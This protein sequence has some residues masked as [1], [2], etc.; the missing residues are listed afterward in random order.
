MATVR[1][2]SPMRRF[3]NGERVVTVA[4]GT[5]GDAI[6]DLTGRFPGLAERLLDGDG[7]LYDFVNVFVNDQDARLLQGLSTPVDEGSEISIIPAM[8]GGY[9][10]WVRC[11]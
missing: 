6:Q 9:R 10:S 5:L 8:A 2:P 3:T 4:A 11:R 1:I 7:Q